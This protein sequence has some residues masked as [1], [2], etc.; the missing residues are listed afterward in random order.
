[1]NDQYVTRCQKRLQEWDAPLSGWYCTEVMDMESDNHQCELC[2]CKKVR[3]IH[4]MTHEEF[5]IP[6]HVGCICA[7]IMNGDIIAAK[8]RDRKMKNRARRRLNFPKRKWKKVGAEA[9]ILKYKGQMVWIRHNENVFKVSCNEAW[10]KQYKGK[11]INN[12]LSA[13]YAA[14][15]LV[16]PIDEVLG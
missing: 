1:M 4:V 15:D 5:Y 9:H 13:V 6:L 14:F 2:D 16:D 8:E 3:F 10:T 7:G 11:P 12:F